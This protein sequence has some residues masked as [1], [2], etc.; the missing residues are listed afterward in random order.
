M[1][2][3]ACCSRTIRGQARTAS[4]AAARSCGRRSSAGR[5][6]EPAAKYGALVAA[7]IAVVLMLLHWRRHDS[8]QAVELL[9]ATTPFGYTAVGL[10]AAAVSFRPRAATPRR[11][12]TGCTPPTNS[13]PSTP[14]PSTGRRSLKN[15]TATPTER[16]A[17]RM[18]QPMALAHWEP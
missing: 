13:R 12:R 11:T 3:K 18:G 6:I 7:G 8:V 1:S 14:R 15:S 4:G 9:G 2:V 10:G 16:P 5:V 17:P